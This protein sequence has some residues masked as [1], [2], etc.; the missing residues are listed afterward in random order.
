MHCRLLIAPLE[1]PSCN[2]SSHVNVHSL[3]TMELRRGQCRLGIAAGQPPEHVCCRVYV[4]S[5]I[6]LTVLHCRLGCAADAA[7]GG[8]HS[9]EH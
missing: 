5:Q 2:I 6:E 7:A 4:V 8:C 1:H 3:S 9:Q